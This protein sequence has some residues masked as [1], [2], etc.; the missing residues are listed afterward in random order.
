MRAPVRI[1]VAPGRFQAIAGG[2]A[3]GWQGFLSH[4]VGKMVSMQQHLTFTE[5]LQ[6][7]ADWRLDDHTRSVGRQGIAAARARLAACKPVALELDIA[8]HSEAA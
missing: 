8:T 2:R 1:S 3:P 4:P 6:L 7:Q 5:E